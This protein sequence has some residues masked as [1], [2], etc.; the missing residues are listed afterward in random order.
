M[1]EGERVKLEKEVVGEVS[2]VE[3]PITYGCLSDGTR[4]TID[5]WILPVVE[6][7]RVIDARNERLSIQNYYTPHGDSIEPI[8]PAELRSVFIAL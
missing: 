4:R 6:K 5:G 1:M 2:E 3:C 7:E 8:H